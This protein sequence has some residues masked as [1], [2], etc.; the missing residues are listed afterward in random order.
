MEISASEFTKKTKFSSTS[1][2]TPPKIKLK[3]KSTQTPPKIKS[4]QKNKEKIE[5]RSRSR[6]NSKIKR[7]K[8]ILIRKYGVPLGYKKRLSKKVDNCYK[9]LKVL[10]EGGKRVKSSDS[11]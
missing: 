7:R 10:G 6:E 1:S 2:Q 5:P 11:T 4:S 9:M 3:S 8:R